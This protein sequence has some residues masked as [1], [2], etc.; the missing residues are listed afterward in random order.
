MGTSRIIQVKLTP[1]AAANRV[2]ALT[3]GMDGHMILPVYVTSVPED[4]KANEAML[5]LLAKHL[6]VAVTRLRIVRGHTAR[7]KQ[8]EIED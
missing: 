4:G 7:L 8:I 5:R 3:A 6:G 1:K 2:G